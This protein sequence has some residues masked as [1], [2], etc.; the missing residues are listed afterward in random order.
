MNLSRNSPLYPST[1]ASAS[2]FAKAFYIRFWLD[3]NKIL[4][5][6]NDNGATDFVT[7]GGAP[8]CST[9]EEIVGGITELSFRLFDANFG[10]LNNGADYNNRRVFPH[11]VQITLKMMPK[12]AF[13]TWRKRVV[14]GGG[15]EST[16]QRQY[17]QENEYEFVRIIYL[18]VY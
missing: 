6:A 15:T 14:D 12:D 18:G 1:H 8:T 7:A 9:G 2:D 16:E 11:S 3:G 17:R 4:R 13:D 5:V 10:V